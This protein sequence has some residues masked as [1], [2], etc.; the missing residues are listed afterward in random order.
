MSEKERERKKDREGERQGEGD[1]E[2]LT[3]RGRKGE[4]DKQRE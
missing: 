1:I 3:E 4:A 2:R